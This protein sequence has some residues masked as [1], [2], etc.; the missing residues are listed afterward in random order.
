MAG[1][2]ISQLF[3]VWYIINTDMLELPHVLVG[4]AIATTIPDPRISLPLALV[5]HFITDYVPHWNPHIHTELKKNGRISSLSKSIL[6]L[7]SGGALF[8]GT[9]IASRALPDTNKFIVIMLACFLAVAPDVVEIPYYIFRSDNLWI[10]KLISFQRAHQ[11]N[12]P[13]FWG[14][15]AQIIVVSLCLQV[16]F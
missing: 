7:D 4:A 9:F 6:F 11:W 12:V 8:L 1:L 16:I 13:A 2:N 14:I 3:T 15:L 10:K 5:S